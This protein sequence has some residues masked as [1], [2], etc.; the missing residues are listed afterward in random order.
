MQ[1]KLCS[2]VLP[3]PMPGSSTIRSRG[4][5]ARAAMSSE[6]RKKAVTSATMSIAG[7]TLSRLC[8]TMTG[9]RVVGDDARHVGVALQAPN[10]IDD[11]R[12]QVERP[13]GDGGF[14]RIDRHRNAE[15]DD[16]GQ[17]RGQPRAFLLERYA[18]GTAIGPRRFRADIENIGAFRGETAGM[19]DGRLRI[20]KAAAVGK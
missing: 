14:E 1:V 5:P 19:R 12:A 18:N 9:A 17:E 7:S 20:E 16:I 11:R 2:A 3:K 8:M 10:V 4:M 6:R 13:G 15:R